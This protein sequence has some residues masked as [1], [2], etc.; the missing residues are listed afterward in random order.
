MA[1][2]VLP[3]HLHALGAPEVRLGENLVTFTTRKTLAFLIYLA[4]E[5]G[6]QPREHLAA[7]LWPEASP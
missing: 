3:L 4:I 7:L 1:D 2:Q 6:A 5:S